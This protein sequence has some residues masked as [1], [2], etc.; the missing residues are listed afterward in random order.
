M[1]LKAQCGA[2]FPGRRI[3]FGSNLFLPTLLFF[4]FLLSLSSTR[5]S[6]QLWDALTTQREGEGILCR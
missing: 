3:P 4:L 1:I 5:R 6:S 2:P